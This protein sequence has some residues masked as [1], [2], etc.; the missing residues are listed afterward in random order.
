MV[1][2]LWC[3]LS[4]YFEDNSLE[5]SSK[6]LPTHKTDIVVTKPGVLNIGAGD[7]N[8]MNS[9]FA[10]SS[11]DG[12]LFGLKSVKVKNTL[13][14]NGGG[15]DKSLYHFGN[16]TSNNLLIFNSIIQAQ[17]MSSPILNINCNKRLFLQNSDIKP[18][19]EALNVSGI[20]ININLGG[21]NSAQIEVNDDPSF[22]NDTAPGA[23]FIDSTIYSGCSITAPSALLTG[24][25]NYGILSAKT[26]LS[27]SSINYGTLTNK[28][29]FENSSNEGICF[30]ETLFISNS[31]NSKQGQLYGNSIF[32]GTASNNGLITST[33]S[34]LSSSINNGIIS[35]AL[36]TFSGS[37]INNSTI[38]SNCLF[39]DSSSNNGS[40]SGSVKFYK[41]NNTGRVIGNLYMISGQS[42]GTISGSCQF[43]ASANNSNINGQCI[44][45]NSTNNGNV[46]GSANFSDQSIN[47]GNITKS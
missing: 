7:M 43:I 24:S 19:N 38:Y 35:G 14:L 3:D 46:N 40:V 32:S 45:S 17:A 21:G 18:Y 33:T 23:Y 22:L 9:C 34:F 10:Q 30:S 29:Q 27:Q 1:Q 13:V 31:N 8:S 15:G 25:K 11:D 20:L 39:I 16:I 5:N 28:A 44:F 37:A 6:F 36:S 47:N 12:I 26:T 4:N 41:S 2:N 42:N